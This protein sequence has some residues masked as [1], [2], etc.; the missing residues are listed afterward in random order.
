MVRQTVASIF[1]QPCPKLH[2]VVAGTS[3][4]RC[5]HARPRDRRDGARPSHSK[6]HHHLDLLLRG[7]ARLGPRMAWKPTA[8]A[9]LIALLPVYGRLTIEACVEMQLKVLV[10]SSAAARIWATGR[11]AAPDGNW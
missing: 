10:I 1:D 4:D 8:S 2:Q 9:F 5:K 6:P 7:S 3:D 11:S